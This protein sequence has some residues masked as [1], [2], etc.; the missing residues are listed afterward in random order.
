MN[1]RQR[2]QATRGGGPTYARPEMQEPFN[3]IPI[4]NLLADHPSLRYPEVRAAAAALRA[5][6][7][8]RKPPFVQWRNDYDL[9]N[10]LGLFFGFQDDNVRNQREHLVLHL[11]NSQMRLQPPPNL[12]DVLE[13]GVLR[14]FRRKLL[15]NYKSWCAYLGRRSNII[16][17]RRRGGDDV[18]RE[19]LYVALYL[20]VWGES[21]NLRF[22]PECICYIFHHMAMEL[23]QVLDEDID[24]ETGRPFLPVSGDRAFLRSVIVPIYNTIKEEVEDSR[25]GTRPHSAWRNY[26]DINEYFW[27]RRCFKSLKWPINYSSNFFST[28]PKEIRVGKTG[29]VEQRS[30]WNLFRSFDKLWV[31]LFL[32]LQ[33][34]LI[35][36]WEGK[37]YPWQALESRD[38][39]VRLLTVFITW[40]GLRVLQ[41]VLDA[42]TQYSL[43]TKETLSLGI[44]MVLKGIVATT[45]TIIFSVFYAR[46]WAQKN[47]DGRWSGEAN[48]RIVDFLWTALVL[49]SQ[50]CWHWFCL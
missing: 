7:D 17:H 3:I 6:G 29:F 39:Q 40:G 22:V 47:S 16:I 31:L 10:W 28:A 13:S 11:A 12:A 42:G 33:A 36:A 32:F 1:L 5:V 19:L 24:P 38:V 20:L 15:E 35:V 26:D 30:F 50:N 25:N 14:R 46:I 4:H 2:P 37:E 45:W 18:R 27:S 8:L 49:L 41:A 43:V 23:N 44:R 9:M 48:K 21:G 34:A